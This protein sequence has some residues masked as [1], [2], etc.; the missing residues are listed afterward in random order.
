MAITT[1]GDAQAAI[2]LIRHV[3]REAHHDPD[4]IRAAVEQLANSAGTRMQT[5]VIYDKHTL[6][7]ALVAA[8]KAAQH[9]V[10]R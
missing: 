7:A 1:N 10:D 2:D 3:T 5:T 4:R 9:G 6:D 8:Q